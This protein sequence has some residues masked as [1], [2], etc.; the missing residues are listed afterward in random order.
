MFLVLKPDT[1]A[2]AVYVFSHADELD[3]S[4]GL[5]QQEEREQS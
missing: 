1:G 2:F 4:S 5:D 3:T